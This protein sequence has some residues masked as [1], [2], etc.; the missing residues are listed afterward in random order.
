M[1]TAFSKLM[2]QNFCFFAINTKPLKWDWVIA[3]IF[4]LYVLER[5]VLYIWLWLS[6]RLSFFSP[7]PSY[8]S[9]RQDQCGPRCHPALRQI[10]WVPLS[11]HGPYGLVLVLKDTGLGSSLDCMMRKWLTIRKTTTNLFM[12]KKANMWI[13]NRK[14]FLSWPEYLWLTILVL[15]GPLL[16]CVGP[17]ERVQIKAH[18]PSK[19]L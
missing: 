5:R 18:I 2:H 16:H 12:N 13:Y 17:G 9:Y 15:A 19:C 3:D 4:P 1:I 10:G 11:S 7:I 14:Y 6:F 8:S